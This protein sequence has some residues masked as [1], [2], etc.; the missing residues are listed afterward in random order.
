MDKKKSQLQERLTSLYLRLNGYLQSGYIPHS[1]IWGNAGT[2]IDRIGIRFPHHSQHEREIQESTE[3]LIPNDSIDIV[4]AEVKASKV[5]FNDTLKKEEKRANQNWEQILRWIGLFYEQE[6]DD[7]VPKIINVVKRNGEKSDNSFSIVKHSNDFNK[8]TLRPI[9]FV[10]DKPINPES[11]KLW[12]DGITVMKY[13]WDCFC[14]EIRRDCCS[15]N[16][17]LSL[18]GTE[19]EDIVEYFKNR[20][21][22]QKGV[23]TLDNLYEKLI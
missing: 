7:L 8:I 13:L 15:T 3:L 19:Y 2:D 21:I 5:A 6:I 10:F 17:P 11:S 23:G 20:H 1:E 22:A 9:L 12:I 16:Y 14:P 4:I 18:W